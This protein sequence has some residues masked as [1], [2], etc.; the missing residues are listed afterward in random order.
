VLLLDEPLSS[1]DAEL[2]EEIGV[3]LRRIQQELGVTTV[4][5]THDRDETFSL[6][7][8]VAVV[9][10]GVL[11]QVGAPID[12]YRRPATAFVARALGT[13]NLIPGIV[14]GPDGATVLVDTSL[15][16]LRVTANGTAP[17]PG[18]ATTV[19]A[20]PEHLRLERGGSGTVLGAAFA[21]DALEL[22]VGD[23]EASVRVRVPASAGIEP[24]TAVTVGFDEAALVL[25]PV[26]PG[27][28]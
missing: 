11:E 10:D 4:Y 21:R 28:R 9:R 17:S 19:V 15:G 24:G 23:G 13:A 20:R 14:R 16:C 26:E 6:S 18:A 12:L 8:H 27:A 2:R 25:V 5:V 7:T 22:V 3:E 1:L